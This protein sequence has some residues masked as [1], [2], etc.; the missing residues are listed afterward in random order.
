MD[1]LIDLVSLITCKKVRQTEENSQNFRFFELMT[2][3]FF[4]NFDQK[5]F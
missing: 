5:I 3:N 1:N 2:K 4:G